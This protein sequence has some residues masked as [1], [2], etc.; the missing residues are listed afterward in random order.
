MTTATT[1]DRAVPE[2]TWV[3]DDIHSNANFEVEHSGLSTFRGGFKPVGAKLVA[4]ADGTLLEGSVR[5]D[6]VTIEDEDLR[7]HLLS[8][9]FFDAERNPEITYRSTEISG[10]ADDLRIAGEL[11]M[12]GVTLPVEARGRI[13]GPVAGAD[14]ERLALS[15]ETSIDRTEYGMNWQMD[16]PA[17]GKAL[18]DDVKLIVDLEFKRDEG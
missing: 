3:V 7:P 2:G 16:L 6:S 9:D 11:S 8:P 15:L 5:V 10:A 18:G 1:V 4:G 13:R 12:A 14:V 17:G